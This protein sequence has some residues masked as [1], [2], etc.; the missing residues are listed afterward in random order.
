MTGA[1]SAQ[2]FLDTPIRMEIG[3]TPGGGLFFTGGDNDSEANFNVY[4]FSSHVDYYLTQRLAVEGEYMF[5]NGWGQDIIYR[6]G[7]LVGQQTPFSH[8]F[9]GG[10]LFYPRGTTGSRL[11]FYFSGG[12]GMMSLVARPST[13][14]V[15][16]DPEENGSESFTVSR[17]GAGMKIRARHRSELV[18][19]DGLPSIVHQ[20]EQRRPRVFRADRY[21]HR[22]PGAVRYPVCL[23]ALTVGPG[24]AIVR[25]ADCGYCPKLLTE[26]NVASLPTA[27]PEVGDDRG[28]CARQ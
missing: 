23:Q 14:K 9:T 21:A 22:S 26:L 25:R 4:T 8:T 17:I 1:V 7:L 13:K 11:P 24:V 28:P 6:N 20:R 16:Y 27:R 3:G 2:E 10:V 15:G 5:G 18:V 19:Q 12:I